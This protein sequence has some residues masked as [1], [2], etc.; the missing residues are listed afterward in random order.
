MNFHQSVVKPGKKAPRGFDVRD[1]MRTQLDAALV[2]LDA[3]KPSDAVHRCRTALKRARALARLAARAEP[4]LSGQMIARIRPVMQRFDAVRDADAL[5]ACA[6]RFAEA[7]EGE[8]RGALRTVARKL[9]AERRA[10]PPPPLEE[11]RAD[12]RALIALLPAWPVIAPDIIR[13]G[14][15]R[16][17]RRA[18]RA[19]LRARDTGAI[20]DRHTWRKRE[21]ERL[22]AALLLGAEW[23]KDTPRRR[24]RGQALGE[25]LGA[26][27]DAGLLIARLA[28]DPALAGAPDDADRALAALMRR[29]DELNRV[30]A[31]LGRALHAR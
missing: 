27:R 14:A 16:L 1:A 2:A 13:E 23:P 3:V 6:R 18:R 12:V 10:A 8:A 30:A 26:E 28:Q 20:E 15:R 17:A 25:A 11:A 31:R 24:R 9:A 7:M 4:G 22:Y 5:E 19:Y 21:K 29:Q